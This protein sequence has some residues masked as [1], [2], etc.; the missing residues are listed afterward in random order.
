MKNTFTI[1]FHVQ[2][3]IKDFK[4][5]SQFPHWLDTKHFQQNKFQFQSYVIKLLHFG[6]K[7]W[8][9]QKLEIIFAKLIF[10]I[11]KFFTSFFSQSRTLDNAFGTRHRV[12]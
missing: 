3:C 10:V 8:A 6:I 7:I 4:K 5:V 12:Y 2:K 9:D 11:L 1:D